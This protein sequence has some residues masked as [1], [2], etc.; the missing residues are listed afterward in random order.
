MPEVKCEAEVIRVIGGEDGEEVTALHFGPYDNGY[1]LIGLNSGR[2]LVYDPITLNRVKDFNIFT[3]GH[4]RGELR[5]AEA[6][7]QIAI[8]PT[9][10]VFL[11]G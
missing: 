4:V 10:L 7:T 5:Q 3:R 9:E 6:I 8:E 1:V 11:T 2:L